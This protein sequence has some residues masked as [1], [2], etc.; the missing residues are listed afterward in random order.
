M[1]AEHF[2]GE[3]G[4]APEIRVCRD[5]E[6]VQQWMDRFSELMAV[7]CFFDTGENYLLWREATKGC[8]LLQGKGSFHR[9]TGSRPTKQERQMAKA[10]RKRS[11]CPI[12]GDCE[13]V[14]LPGEYP[15]DSTPVV[16]IV[17][18]WTALTYL[19]PG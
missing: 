13:P 14:T 4:V 12:C 5:F 15:V 10:V 1:L 11:S 3:T 8:K 17:S 2:A 6:T 18:P 7:R 16:A 19:A 9:I